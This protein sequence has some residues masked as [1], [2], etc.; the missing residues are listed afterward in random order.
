MGSHDSFYRILGVNIAVSC[1]DPQLRTLM[2]SHWGRMASSQLHGDLS[3]TVSRNEST[4][5]ISITRTGQPTKSTTDEGEFLYELE[6]DANMAVQL[7]RRDLYFLHAAVAEFEG[8]AYLFVAESGGG[9]STTLWGLLHHDWGYLSDEL[10]PIEL[11]S[12]HVQAYPRALCLKSRPSPAYPLPDATIHTPRTS[13]I[14]VK[15]LPQVSDLE[16]CPLVPAYFVNYCPVASAPAVRAITAGEAAARLYANTLNQL[17]H[18]NAGLDAAVQI[19]K[20]IPGFALDSADLATTCA[21][22]GSHAIAGLE[23]K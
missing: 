8:G 18:T 13:H 6:S 12:M 5:A 14:P 16:S 4:S 17:A 9:K 1:P 21:V 19:A 11:S 2:Q 22:V 7:L 23:N 20:N 3:Y 15:H 10:A